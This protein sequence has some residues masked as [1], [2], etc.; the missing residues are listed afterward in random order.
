M[1]K[2]EQSIQRACLDYLL[3]RRHFVWK[4]S[5]VGIKK[6]NGSFIPTGKKGVSDIVGITKDGKFLAVE[7]KAPKGI[8]SEAQS[9]FLLQIKNRGGISLVA[10][11]VNDLINAGL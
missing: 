1:A 2:I 3:L 5:T 11:S 10:R 4:V 6:E 7:V 9:D 8:L